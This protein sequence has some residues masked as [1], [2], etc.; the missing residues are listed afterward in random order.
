MLNSL[1][2][3]TEDNNHLEDNKDEDDYDYRT[4]VKLAYQWIS[5]GLYSIIEY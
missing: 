3:F 2:K 5:N 4:E 1:L